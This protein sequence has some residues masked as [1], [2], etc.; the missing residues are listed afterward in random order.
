MLGFNPLAQR[1]DDTVMAR[2]PAV[3]NR[4]AGKLALQGPKALKMADVASCRTNVSEE[5]RNVIYSEIKLSEATETNKGHRMSVGTEWVKS[6]YRVA[7]QKT[8]IFSTVS[9][10]G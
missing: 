7:C 5:E 9:V 4:Y 3:L 1:Q 8:I 6:L 2:C 10:D